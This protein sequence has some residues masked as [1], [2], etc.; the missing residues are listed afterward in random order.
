MQKGHSGLRP[1]FR[2]LSRQS[3]LAPCRDSGFGVATRVGLARCFW[4]ATKPPD[5]MSRHDF[6]C[7]AT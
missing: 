3:F 1:I 2:F 6:P 7:V 5:A 4:V